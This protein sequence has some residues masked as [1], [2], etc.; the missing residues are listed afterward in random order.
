MFS[1]TKY[2]RR[3]VELETRHAMLLKE[4]CCTR[5]RGVAT[6]CRYVQLARPSYCIFLQ[7]VSSVVAFRPDILDS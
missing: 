5:Q 3:R 7:K 1:K 4:A 2:S 6:K